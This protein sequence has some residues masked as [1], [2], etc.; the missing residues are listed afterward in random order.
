MAETAHIMATVMTNTTL[1]LHVGR[2]VRADSAEGSAASRT[3][4]KPSHAHEADEPEKK[5]LK[6]LLFAT[7]FAARRS[8]TLLLP[9]CFPLGCAPCVAA[10]DGVWRGLCIVLL[11]LAH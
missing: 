10:A 4:K 7:H 8:P 9:A 1:P 11:I 2:H 6:A 3:N 5:E